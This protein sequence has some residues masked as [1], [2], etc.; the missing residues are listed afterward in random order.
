MARTLAFDRETVVRAALEV[1]WRAGYESASI[2]ELERETGLSRS[3]IYN[4]FG[5]KRGLFDAAVQLYLGDIIRPRLR[6]LLDADPDPQAITVYLEGL[7]TT[8]QRS[9]S[10]PALAG[11][12]LIN[13][14]GSPIA[15]DPVVAETIAGYRGELQSAFRH[16]ILARVPDLTPAAAERLASACTGQVIAA[17]ALVRVSASEAAQAVTTALELIASA[18]RQ[19][20]PG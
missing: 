8:L 10:L 15:D 4:S 18:Q 3:S 9:D 20:T 17:F 2:P 1:F 7:R 19:Q 16:G 14:A 12:L 6:P 13:T 11:C 5:S